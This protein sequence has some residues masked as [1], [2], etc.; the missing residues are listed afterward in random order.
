[1]PRT[2]AES[3]VSLSQGLFG[4]PRRS[5]VYPSCPGGPL[6]TTTLLESLPTTPLPSSEE[7][8]S[9]CARVADDN[10]AKNIVVLDL[11]GLTPL[12][13]FFVLMTGASRRQMH[14]LGGRNRGGHAQ[15]R[16]SP[17]VDAGLPGSRW[18]V[19]DF[20]DVMVHVFDQEAREYYALDDLWA[21][22]EWTGSVAPFSGKPSRRERAFTAPR[23]L[24]RPWI[25]SDFERRALA[26]R[27]SACRW[28]SR[29]RPF[30]MGPSSRCTSCTSCKTNFAR[31]SPASSPIRNRTSPWCGRRRTPSTATT[32]PTAPCRSPRPR[33]EAA[34][35]RP[36]DRRPARP[37]ATCSKRRKSP[38]RASS[39]CASRPTGSPRMVGANRPRRPRSA[40]RR[41]HGKKTFVIDFSSPNVAKPMHVGHLRSTIIGDALT[42]LLRFLGHTVITDNH[43][44][45]WGTQFGMLLYGYKHFLDEAA[46]DEDPVRELARL[47]VHRPRA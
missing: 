18:I 6:E 32:R 30:C 15:R 29:F 22:A 34:R 43:L 2:L 42:R 47:Y 5:G 23:T 3:A 21:D 11:R 38:A 25:V 4:C 13:D 31:P 33:Q 9:L 20:G 14:T 46:F 39:T 37:R 10:K 28:V 44:G 41:S 27:A 26:E 36:G 1:M 45:D 19:E 35:H 17:A 7:R 40:S 16:R 12:Y 24:S 8:A